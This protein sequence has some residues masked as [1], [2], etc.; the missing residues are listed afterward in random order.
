MWFGEETKEEI[1]I[2][3]TNY[4][5]KTYKKTV[6]IE[7]FGIFICNSEQKRRDNKGDILETIREVEESPSWGS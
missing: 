7:V 2:Y 4:L 6:L 3:H 1:W 5:E